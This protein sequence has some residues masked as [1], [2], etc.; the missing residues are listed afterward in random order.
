MCHAECLMLNVLCTHFLSGALHGHLQLEGPW[1]HQPAGGCP[2]DLLRFLFSLQLLSR[3]CP[4]EGTT[5]LR[6]C[7][8]PLLPVATSH[9]HFLFPPNDWFHKTHQ[10]H[11]HAGRSE[12]DP[13]VI[14]LLRPNPPRLFYPSHLLHLQR[15]TET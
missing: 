10:E 8:N 15:R 4:Q 12:S 5:S 11:R 13:H 9:L 6:P 3:M 1:T 2:A 7:W 14:P